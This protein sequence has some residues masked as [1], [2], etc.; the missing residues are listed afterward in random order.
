M[1]ILLDQSTPIG[2]REFLQGH[3]VITAREQGWSALLNGQLLRS[4][5]E[6]GFDL[7]LTADKSLIYQQNLRERRIAIVALST[8]R[9]SVIKT[10]RDKIVSA[11]NAAKPGSYALAEPAA[12][13]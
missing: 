6:A 1:R 10:M 12:R 13:H 5:D 7:F 4:A 9:W 2:V 8:N 3:I 11:V